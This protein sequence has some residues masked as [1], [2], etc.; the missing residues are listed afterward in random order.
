MCG[1]N[2]FC[3]SNKIIHFQ[4]ITMDKAQ[5]INIHNISNYRKMSLMSVAT[6]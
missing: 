2:I 4:E 6:I 1:K 3:S 5:T